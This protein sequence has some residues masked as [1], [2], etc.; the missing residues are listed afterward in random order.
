[1]TVIETFFLKTRSVSTPPDAPKTTRRREQRRL[2]GSIANRRAR[3]QIQ[4]A[5]NEKV[6]RDFDLNDSFSD[7]FSRGT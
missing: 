3:L 2:S 5:T 1:M 7:D 6:F 4:G